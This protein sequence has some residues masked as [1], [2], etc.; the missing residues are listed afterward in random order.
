MSHGGTNPQF[1]SRLS[2]DIALLA[3][4]LL[5]SARGLLGEPPDY[6]I[7]RL[8]EGARRALELLESTGVRDSRFIEVRSRLDDI[9]YGPM[10]EMD[11]E[12]PL[13]DLCE[14]MVDGL[15]TSP[16]L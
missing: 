1:P 5:S 15:E 11:F 3:A 4:Y 2:E 7:V 9:M 10:V 12:Q 8:I 16:R 14:R 13:D 6:G